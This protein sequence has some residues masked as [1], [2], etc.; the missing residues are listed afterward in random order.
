MLVQPCGPDS[1]VEVVQVGGLTLALALAGS[2]SSTSSSSSSSDDSVY[3]VCPLF[4]QQR[5]GQE[6]WRVDAY[7][8]T[9]EGS[10]GS[11]GTCTGGRAQSR[12]CWWWCWW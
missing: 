5:Q 12:Q 3:Y 7:P 4:P 2:T 8:E 10:S 1:A 9:D 11:S 6:Q